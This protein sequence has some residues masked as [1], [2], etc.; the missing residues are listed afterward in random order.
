MFTKLETVVQTLYGSVV[1][2]N[3]PVQRYPKGGGRGRRGA[4][5]ETGREI[6]NLCVKTS[7]F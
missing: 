2:N 6:N 1:K 5:R 4:E 3:Y 7:D